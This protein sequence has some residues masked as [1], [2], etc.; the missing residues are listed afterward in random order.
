MHFEESEKWSCKLEKLIKRILYDM[1]M[2][3]KCRREWVARSLSSET[4]A[5]VEI[6]EHGM[7]VGFKPYQERIG[8]PNDW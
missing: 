1:M 3:R 5:L 4:T 2:V 7:A 8:K 6:S